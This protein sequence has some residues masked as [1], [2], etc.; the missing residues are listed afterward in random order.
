MGLFDRFKKPKADKASQKETSRIDKK[1]DQEKIRKQREEDIK[2]RQFQAVGSTG[3]APKK[4]E[5]TKEKDKKS[6]EKKKPTKTETGIAPRIIVRPIITEKAT[7][8]GIYNKYAFEVSSR[9]NKIEVKKAI[10]D[11]YGVRPIKIG[12]INVRGR[13]V[14]YGRSTGMTKSWKKAIITLKE[15]DKID[16]NV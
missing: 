3:A 16:I 5:K 12:I 7:E 8:L 6:E 10:Y 15:G 1:K 4:E 9:A 11:L 2:K 14:R 13:A